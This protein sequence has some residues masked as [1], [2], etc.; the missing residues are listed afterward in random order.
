MDPRF[1]RAAEDVGNIVKLEHVNVTVPDQQLAT[2]FYVT[3]L[4]LTRD[5]YIMTGVDNMWINVGESQFHLPTGRP[6]VLRGTIGLVLPDLAALASRLRGVEP[7]LEGT[8]FRYALRDDRVEVSCPWGN[9]IRCHAA[10]PDLFGER[11]LGMAYV[12]LDVPEG[13]ASHIAAF[14]RDVLG[15][16]ARVED[17]IAVVTAGPRQSLRFRETREPV[18]AYDGHHVQIYVA[19]FS[20]PHRRLLER[21]LVSRETDQHEY[22]FIRIVDDRGATQFELEHEVRSLRHPLCGRPL[23]NRNPAQSN[24]GYLPGRDA[25]W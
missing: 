14:Y 17:R 12:E 19:D 24:R 15:A 3:G 25:W 20:G 21:G 10:S 11:T 13:T 18:A 1:D 4:G 2:I 16:P 7:A 22:R 5:P 9:R 23:V 8:A 6:Q